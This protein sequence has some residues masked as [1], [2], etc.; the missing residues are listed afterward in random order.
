MAATAQDHVEQLEAALARNAGVAE[1]VTD[2]VKV[3]YNRQQLLDEL[4][5]WRRRLAS[6]SK[7]RRVSRGVNLG[8]A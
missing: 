1:V 4:R 5:Y 7:R 3:R 6:E 8:G 2:G